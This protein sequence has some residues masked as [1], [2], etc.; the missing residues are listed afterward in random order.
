M[1]GGEECNVAGDGPLVCPYPAPPHTHTA[2]L[3]HAPSATFRCCHPQGPPPPHPPLRHWT[4]GSGRRS[5]HCRTPGR[6]PPLPP[7]PPRHPPCLWCC[8][9]AQ[10]PCCRLPACPPPPSR[11]R[12]PYR[13]LGA[14]VDAASGPRHHPRWEHPTPQTPP[15]RRRHPRS[16][17]APPGLQSLVRPGLMR[18]GCGCTHCCGAPAAQTAADEGVPRAGCGACALRGTRAGSLPALP[19]PA[20]SSGA[21]ASGWGSP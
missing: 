16:S 10:A 3:F 15:P 9:L 19:H 1:G 17:K 8:P 20:H 7:P 18:T 14:P 2:F 11:P 21:P 13:C 4:S 12:T 6:P 5:A